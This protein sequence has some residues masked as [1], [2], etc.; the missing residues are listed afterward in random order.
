MDQKF[1]K[2]RDGKAG[3]APFVY[4]PPPLSS[5]S[6]PSWPLYGL[7]TLRTSFLIMLALIYVLIDQTLA[8]V[9]VTSP[10][11]MKRLSF[12]MTCMICRIALYLLGFTRLPAD[13]PFTRHRSI[14]EPKTQVEAGDVV[15]INWSSYVDIIYLAHIYDPIFILPSPSSRSQDELTI[16]G[17]SARSLLHLITTA[18]HPPSPLPNDKLKTLSEWVDTGRKS[19]QAVV[20]LPEATTSNNRAILR[21]VKLTAELRGV[22]SRDI[23]FF[24]LGLK[25]D[26]PTQF[27]PSITSPIPS[28]FSNLANIFHANLCP[29]LLP[30]FS[31][32][33]L[34]LRYP[35]SGPI[36]VTGASQER[37]VFEECAETLLMVCKMKQTTGIG[38]S[39]KAGFLSYVEGRWGS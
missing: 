37:D 3:V 29:I 11:A 1:S 12:L 31:P 24:C 7:A 39:D 22:H 28:R 26:N 27:R 10:K 16:D 15:V 18:G 34:T 38:W 25:H 17:F 19:G 2:W 30:T 6:Y 21:F 8:V 4:P 14:R 32:R 23:R 13:A 9:L 35:K 20:V 33:S 36:V 5:S